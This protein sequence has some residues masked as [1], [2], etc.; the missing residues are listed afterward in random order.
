MIDF[1]RQRGVSLALVV[2]V[3]VLDAIVQFFISYTFAFGELRHPLGLNLAALATAGRYV[4]IGLM[5]WM[6]TLWMFQCK[7]A[8]FRLVIFVNAVATLV[9]L[10]HVIFLCSVLAGLN[11]RV[12][13]EMLADVVLMAISNMLIFSVWYWVVDPP[14]VEGGLHEDKR[15]AFLFPQRASPLPNFEDWVP[16]YLD[17]LFLAFTTSFAFSPTDALPLTRTAK[18]LMLLQ[19]AVSVITLTGVAGS[20]INILAGTSAGGP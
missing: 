20:A 5:A 12:A 10:L 15:W 8:L 4:R 9:L 7:R 6:A 17:Y 2:L 14:G 13:P 18:M 3:M 1:F 19:A 16:R 11:A